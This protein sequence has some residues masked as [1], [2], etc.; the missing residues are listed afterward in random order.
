VSAVKRED[1]QTVKVEP[2]S[3]SIQT[4]PRSREPSLLKSVAQSHLPDA[5]L[6]VQMNKSLEYPKDRMAAAEAVLD[7]PVEAAREVDSLL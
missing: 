3:Y 2:G 4:T 6:R 5:L 7:L 1:D